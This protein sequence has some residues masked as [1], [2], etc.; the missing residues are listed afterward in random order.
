MVVLKVRKYGNSLGVVL[1][2]EVIDRLQTGDSEALFLIE[3]P[4]GEYRLTA[5][6]PALKKKM[7]KA[8]EIVRATAMLCMF[9]PSEETSLDR[10]TGLALRSLLVL[11]PQNR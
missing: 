11:A 3:A 6:D 7:T 1:P 9:S 4:E 10:R 5:Y 2:N 8:D